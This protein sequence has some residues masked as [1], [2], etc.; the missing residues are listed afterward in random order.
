MDAFSGYHP[1]IN[2]TYFTIVIGL[3]MFYMH[4]VFLALSL[5]LSLIHILRLM[6]WRQY[7]SKVEQS[8]S[9]SRDRIQSYVPPLMWRF[10]KRSRT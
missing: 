4:P 2:F 6:N 8:A 7:Q 5:A 9:E 1:L 10:Q 3:S